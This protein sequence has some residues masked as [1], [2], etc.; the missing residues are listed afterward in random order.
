MVRQLNDMDL[1]KMVR[2]RVVGN[3]LDHQFRRDV[4]R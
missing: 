4:V 2:Q 3:F 1:K